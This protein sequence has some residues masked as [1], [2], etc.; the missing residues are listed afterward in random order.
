VR[1]DVE[2]FAKRVGLNDAQPPSATPPDAVADDGASPVEHAAEARTTF[3]ISLP[4]CFGCLLTLL[5]GKR[6][7]TA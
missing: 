7:A 1:V 4:E 2:S 5:C 6:L 3:A